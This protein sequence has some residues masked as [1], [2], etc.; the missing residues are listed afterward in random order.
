MAATLDH[1][2]WGG[3]NLP[4]AIDTLER[5]TGVRAT[6]GGQHP[7]LGTHNALAALGPKTFIEVI[8]PDPMLPAGALARRLQKF[9]APALLMW[10]AATTNA[11]EIAARATAEGYQ[12]TV[13]D[14]HRTRTDG[15]VIRWTN[16]FVAGHGA[17]ILV[18][19]F[20]Q[21]TTPHHPAADAP[22]GLR[23]K[24]LHA[25][26]PQPAALKAVLESLQ[27]KLAVRKGDVARLVAVLDTPR[28]L[29]TLASP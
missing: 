21:W 27:V 10:A 16:V 17:G 25:E 20:I 8:A 4:V 24:R 15:E 9:E 3:P 18:P 6:D 14:G 28:G 2:L 11:A 1:I 5:L 29:V 13:V 26:T 23:L 12:A 7:D 19:F 22:S